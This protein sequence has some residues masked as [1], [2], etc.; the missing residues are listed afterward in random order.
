[1]RQSDVP[2]VG[3]YSQIR[4]RQQSRSPVPSSSDGRR[5]G[6][7]GGAC[8]IKQS[9]GKMLKLK[10]QSKQSQDMLH[11]EVES[12]HP[13]KTAALQILI[14]SYYSIASFSL[15]FLKKN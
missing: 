5:V 11:V 14:A 4:K 2:D 7:V 3:E 1:M 12:A 9:I 13:M 8:S 6:W 15:S 10:D